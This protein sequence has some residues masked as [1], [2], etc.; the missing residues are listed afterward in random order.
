MKHAFALDCLTKRFGSVTAL[1]DV[2]L[3]IPPCS[4]VGLVG[5]N[6]SGK[7]TLL[8]HL[9]GLYL[10]TEGTCTTLG[11]PSPDLG[12][13]T[14]SRIG[15]VHQENRFLEWMTVA[16]HLRYVASFYPAWDEDL[17][18]RLLRDLELDRAARVGTLSVGNAQK[19][20]ILLA[21]CH[22]PD[23]LVL[24]EPVSALDP[25]AR[26][27]LLA[28][29]LELLRE[30]GNTIVISSHVLRDVEKIVD[31]V[32]CL[33]A[34]RLRVNAALDELKERFAEWVVTSKTGK[35]PVYFEEPYVLS[36]EGNS[37][38]ARI[39]VR[40][41]NGRLREFKDRYQAEV[42]KQALNLE[43]M[44]PLFLKEKP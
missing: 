21:V 43:R 3:S 9:V 36:H 27:T 1:N 31:W 5:R 39:Y 38:Q 33:D 35:L 7:T 15:M 25:M 37:F 29:L 8:R 22:R 40:D 4:V 24:D 19:L 20:G 14:L 17:Q 28:F 42:Q 44:F 34:G 11:I 18:N 30:N 23:L 2:T 16:Q 26:E 32:V 13:E 6:G 12:T 41:A 10:P